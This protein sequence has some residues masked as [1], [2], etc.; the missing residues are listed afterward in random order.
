[1]NSKQIIKNIFFSIL[2]VFL[3][4]EIILFFCP[5]REP[6]NTIKQTKNSILKLE[7]NRVFQYSKG[8]LFQ[9]STIKKTNN[10]G[11]TSNFD[12]KI[13]DADILVIGDSFVEAM[14][15]NNNESFHHILKEQ[16]NLNIYQLSHS[17]SNLSQYY[18]FAEFGVKNFNPKLIIYNIV[19]N[20]YVN[21]QVG[22][23]NFD[24]KNGDIFLKESGHTEKKLI[25]KILLKSGI[26]KYL[27]YNLQPHHKINYLL[28]DKDKKF[29]ANIACEY[30]EEELENNKRTF[31]LFLEYNQKFVDDGIDVV[32]MFDEIRSKIYKTN[33]NSCG[34][35]DQESGLASKIKDYSV[36]KQKNKG[37]YTLDLGPY[38]VKAYKK[39]QIKFEFLNDLHWNKYAHKIVALSIVDF[40]KKNLEY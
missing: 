29:E 28:N 16:L 25:H 1:M 35:N 18:K 38:F 36:K 3:F 26:V 2:T 9:I 23:Y 37:I 7:P 21:H 19:A 6:S 10:Y 40:L 17:S 27:Y 39:D 31:E 8:G 5:V 24:L 20:D 32:I 33:T 30:T 11:Y 34:F 4:F 13:N 22:K 12:Y 14:D 15:V